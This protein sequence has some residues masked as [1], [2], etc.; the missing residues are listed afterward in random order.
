MRFRSLLVPIALGVVLLLIAFVVRSGRFAR[1]NPGLPINRA[2]REAVGQMALPGPDQ[3][4]VEQRFPNATVTP[5]GLRYLVT[6]PGTGTQR[7]QRGEYVTVHYQGRLLD[8]TIF[9]DSRAGGKG[10]LNVPVGQG[11]VIPGW[12]EAL[13]DMTEGERRTLIVP[14]W[15]AYGERGARGRIP[16]RATLV[17]DV[18]LLDIH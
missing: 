16:P 9:D 11:R 1:D 15:L 10:P 7:P 5:S 6:Q 12:D 4:I 13:M 8:G 18:E 2:M 17:F 3:A 14:H